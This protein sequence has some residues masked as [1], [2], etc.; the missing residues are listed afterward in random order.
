MSCLYKN[1]KFK[2]KLLE[3]KISTFQ[4]RYGEYFA[5]I[6]KLILA[7]QSQRLIASDTLIMLENEMA[8][9]TDDQI[10]EEIPDVL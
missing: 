10:P 3:E 2:E 8:K 5:K 1:Y 6:I 4:A 9:T 7:E